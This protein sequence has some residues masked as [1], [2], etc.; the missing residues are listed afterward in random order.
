MGK[1][2][3]EI[4]RLLYAKRKQIVIVTGLAALLAILF[5]SSFFIKPKFKSTAVVYPSNIAPYSEE[6]PTEQLMQFLSS[7][8][9]RKELNKKYDL[10]KHYGLDTSAEKF[11]SY[12]GFMF[13]ENFKFSQTRFESIQIEVFDTDPA[14]AQKLAKGLLDAVNGKIRRELDAKTMEILD[15]YSRYNHTKGLVID[16]IESMLIDMSRTSA[17]VDFFAN[18]MP[19]N[20]TMISSGV[21]NYFSEVEKMKD[22]SFAVMPDGK[23]ARLDEIMSF[24]G[25]KGIAYTDMS[26]SLKKERDAF[27][28]A[29]QYIDI[30]IRNLDK[31]FTYYTLVSEPNLPDSKDSPK[32]SVLVIMACIGAFLFSSLYFIFIERIKK[33]RQEI[34]QK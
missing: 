9:I 31:N 19:K 28:E 11:N 18:M 20:P 7:S 21:T 27:L 15:M 1:L 4:L 22:R 26:E 8:D 12:Y 33:L 32:R 3:I 23:T 16:S 34:V 24:L 2:N 6:S 14:M 29:K 10:A 25:K 17:N 30:C 13:D 5:S